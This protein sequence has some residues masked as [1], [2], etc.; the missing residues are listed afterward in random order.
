[1]NEIAPSV[2]SADFSKLAAEIEPI[3]KSGIK[4]LHI[5]VMDG[6]FVPN[7]TFGPSVVKAL[8]PHSKMIFDVHLMISHPLQYA[9]EFAKAG[10]DYIIFHTECDDDIAETLAKIKKLG[11]KCGL[12]IKPKTSPEVLKPF[13][14][15]LDMVLVMTVEPGFGGQKMISECLD[16][17]AVIREYADA[18]G[19]SPLLEVDGGIT[20]ENVAFAA[21]KGA[22]VIVA[23]SSVF[24]KSNPAEA[25]LE[26]SRLANE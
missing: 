17:L 16:K 7:I 1:M 3:E 21:S 18:A 8:R 2:L 11:V 25:A 14:K 10:A 6:H 24:S 26:L 9:E 23:G 19:V 15:E 12:S 22:Q 5:D 13:I 20:A 4:F